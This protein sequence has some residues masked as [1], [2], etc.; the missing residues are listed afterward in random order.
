MGC[1]NSVPESLKGS[2]ISTE[3]PP[4]EW[5]TNTLALLQRVFPN[6]QQPW[7]LELLK[8][9]QVWEDSDF[10]FRQ[11]RR[12]GDF[13]LLRVDNLELAYKSAEL[14]PVWALLVEDLG[15]VRNPVGSLLMSFAMALVR[16]NLE[17]AQ[18][19]SN[20]LAEA[21]FLL[22]S[23]TANVLKMTYVLREAL[24]SFY[25]PI[26]DLLR[27]RHEDVERLVL[28]CIVQGDLYILMQRLAN[29]LTGKTTEAMLKRIHGRESEGG[30]SVARVRELLLQ[31]ILTE[32][33]SEKRD[34]LCKAETHAQGSRTVVQESLHTLGLQ[35]IEADLVLTKLLAQ[36]PG[37]L[38][39]LQECLDTC[40]S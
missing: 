18:Q 11:E 28:D 24:I 16:T 23:L 39:F 31:F 34:L 15:D 37:F 27:A 17:A 7:L 14:H 2:T 30:E 36:A 35:S 5:R 22:A 25:F 19:V 10:D 13:R 21:S 38:Y 4:S 8:G 40:G 12:L 9:V 3:V 32:S 33:I 20:E 29:V 1:T 26:S 6:D